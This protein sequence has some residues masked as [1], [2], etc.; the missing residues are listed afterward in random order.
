MLFLFHL[1]HHAEDWNEHGLPCGRDDVFTNPICLKPGGEVMR[2][3]LK[4]LGYIDGL[5]R[6]CA[7]LAAEDAEAEQVTRVVTTAHGTMTCRMTIEPH[8]AD[9]MK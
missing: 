2:P 3:P 7:K 4:V 6:V 9:W 1:H 5:L 8:L